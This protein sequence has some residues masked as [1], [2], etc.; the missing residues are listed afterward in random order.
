MICFCLFSAQ[1]YKLVENLI[2]PTLSHTYTKEVPL[3]DLDFPLDIK[4]CVKPSMNKT[5]LKMFGYEDV[6]DYIVGLISRSNYSLVG[7]SGHSQNNKRSFASA[8]EIFN[9]IKLNLTKEVI[10]D[11]QIIE[12]DD[13]MLERK[14][15]VQADLKKINRIHACHLLN[16]KPLANCQHEIIRFSFQ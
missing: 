9:A 1:T 5:A 16:R 10:N 14:N 12:N 13:N 8:R 4:I 15:I 7:W 6:Q 3:K 2:V 11:V